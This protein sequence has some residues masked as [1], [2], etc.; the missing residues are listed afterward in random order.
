MMEFDLPE[1]VEL[2][3]PMLER[4]PDYRPSLKDV[5]SS[6]DGLMSRLKGRVP[7]TCPNKSS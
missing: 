2:T 7:H 3:S 4:N 1:L 5:L 6:F